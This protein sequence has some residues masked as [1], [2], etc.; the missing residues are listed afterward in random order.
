MLLQENVRSV[1]PKKFKQQ[2]AQLHSHFAGY[3]Q[4]DSQVG[5][6]LTVFLSHVGVVIVK[7]DTR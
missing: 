7:G 4:H 6:F 3:N 2:I 5:S 1:V